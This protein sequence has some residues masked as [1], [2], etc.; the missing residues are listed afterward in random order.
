[1]SYVEVILLL[2]FHLNNLMSQF[3]I[4]LLD[5]F[6]LLTKANL[7]LHLALLTSNTNHSMLGMKLWIISECLQ[8]Y[9][10]NSNGSGTFVRCSEKGKENTNKINSCS[11]NWCNIRK[12][13]VCVC[14][15]SLSCLNQLLKFDVLESI[16]GG[17]SEGDIMGEK[18]GWKSSLK[19]SRVNKEKEKRHIH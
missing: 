13:F 14:E 10:E 7:Y 3:L 18:R 5:I 19:L 15:R 9:L 17:L 12:C 8:W 1:M 2:W 6:Y 11:C 4:N 16:A